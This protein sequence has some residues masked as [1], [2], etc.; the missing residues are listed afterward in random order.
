MRLVTTITETVAVK[1]SC[2]GRCTVSR[3]LGQSSDR[4]PLHTETEASRLGRAVPPVCGDGVLA[5]CKQV[6]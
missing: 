6:R 3:G 5:W 2:M 4:A 1:N